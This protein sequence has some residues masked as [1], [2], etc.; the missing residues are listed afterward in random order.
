MEHFDTFESL[1]KHSEKDYSDIYTTGDLNNF[2]PLQDILQDNH[3]VYH[4]SFL[5]TSKALFFILN[6]ENPSLGRVIIRISKNTS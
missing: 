4:G 1:L 6:A 2:N 3:M 5:Q